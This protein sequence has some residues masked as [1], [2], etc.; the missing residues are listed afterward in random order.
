[1][2]TTSSQARCTDHDQAEPCGVCATDQQDLAFVTAPSLQR[3]PVVFSDRDMWIAVRSG[4][5][6]VARA[7]ELHAPSGPLTIGVRAGL[8]TIADAIARRYAIKPRK[9]H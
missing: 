7:I 5:L 6:A 1:M 9:S 3:P 4:I 8:L 2:K